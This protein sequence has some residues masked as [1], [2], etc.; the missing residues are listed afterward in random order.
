MMLDLGAEDTDRDY[1]A[2]LELVL[3]QPR[4]AALVNCQVI[5]KV[6]SL[7]YLDLRMFWATPPCTTPPSFGAKTPW[8][9][10]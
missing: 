3:A 1:S 6:L 4:A 9:G 8:P 2:C 7:V 5:F 10:C